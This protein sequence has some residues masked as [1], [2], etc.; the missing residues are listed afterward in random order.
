MARVIRLTE[1]EFSGLLGDI[2]KM[3]LSG[4]IKKNNNQDSDMEDN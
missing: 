1:Q 3:T 4:G 2:L